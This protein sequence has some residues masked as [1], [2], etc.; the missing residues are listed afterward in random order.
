M[1][2]PVA[3]TLVLATLIAVTLFER[4]SLTGLPGLEPPPAASAQT[5]SFSKVVIFAPGIDA[6]QSSTTPCPPV[7][8]DGCFDAFVRAVNTFQPILTLLGCGTTPAAGSALIACAGGVGWAPYSYAGL[9]GGVPAP[10]TGVQT[11]QSLDLSAAHMQ[12][13]VSLIRAQQPSATVVIVAHSLGG[14]VGTYW[15]AG[16]R[17][18]P[19]IT[20]DSPVNGIWP[21]D[22]LS[23]NAYCNAS[24][25][26]FT[27]TQ[28]LSCG[29][30]LLNLP[31][32]TSPAVTQVRLPDTIKQMGQANALNYANTADAFVA[33]WFAVNRLSQQ[34]AVLKTS[35]CFSSNDPLFNHFCIINAAASE[36]ATFVTSGVYPPRSLIRDS[37]T[38]TI[39]ASA[40][41]SPVDGTVTATRL[42]Q[43]V[44]QTHTSGGGAMLTVPWLDT[45]VEFT[46]S[47]GSM[48]LGSLPGAMTNL[49]LTFA[50]WT[51]AP[52][53]ACSPVNPAAGSQTVCTLTLSGPID[54]SVTLTDTVTSP[55]GATITNC[56]IPS[57]LLFC[58]NGSGAS[59]TIQCN[60]FTSSC[61]AG[62]QARLTIRSSAPGVLS[63][64]ILFTPIAGTTP[65]LIFNIAASPPVTFGT[66]PP[67]PTPMPA[68]T[69]PPPPTPAPPPP[70]P[71]PPKPTPAPP[72]PPTPPPPT[73]TPK[74][75]PPPP[76]PALAPGALPP[77]QERRA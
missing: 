57:G 69:P 38:L 76:P 6:F 60:I 18:M 52:S 15:G 43:V 51:S 23:D 12:A 56:T 5:P 13:L 50:T 2:R 41:G 77:G 22:P 3:L 32:A 33:S 62:S 4:S 70:P 48:L 39:S 66:P 71:P 16:D 65:L 44:A 53:K 45:L 29:P 67:T 73:P 31:A 7:N 9:V 47:G 63:E 37:I 36:V 58:R 40:G 42:G 30:L 35:S 14:V 24:V 21:L 74:A 46:Y 11:G 1:P 54:R 17:S 25:G 8:N 34:G 61:A 20:L 26:L 19:V 55:A 49:T 75:T 68:P 59:F 10:Y 28:Q 72:P 64:S 27:P